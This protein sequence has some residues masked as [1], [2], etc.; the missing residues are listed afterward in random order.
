M[1]SRKFSRGSISVTGTS[2][3]EKIVAY[4]MPMTPAP[5]TVRL[6][7]TLGSLAMSSLSKTLVL[8]NGIFFGR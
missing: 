7:G 1:K 5:T 3:A 4:S 6:R 8:L 2:R